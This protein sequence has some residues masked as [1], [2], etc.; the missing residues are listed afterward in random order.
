MKAFVLDIETL[1]TAETAHILSIGLV[2]VDLNKLEITGEFYCPVAD[3]DQE[4]RT[5]SDSTIEWWESQEDQNPQ[6]YLEAIHR[7]KGARSL[8]LALSDMSA[9]MAAHVPEIRDR[10]LFGNGPEFDNKIIEHAYK[11]CGIDSPWRYSNN[12]SI[13]TIALVGK[14]FYGFDH[15]KVPFDGVKHHALDDAKHEAKVL[16]KVW[17]E[18]DNVINLPSWMDGF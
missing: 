5:L 12:Q 13:R 3:V 4:D 1:D 10:Q 14:Q 11:Q 7:R 16:M 15:Y 2:C 8:T 6:A 18:L 9:W 17:A